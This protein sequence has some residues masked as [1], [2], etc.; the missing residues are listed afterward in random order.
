MISIKQLKYALA[1]QKTLHFKKAAELCNVSP[2]A[3]S[4]A[5]NELEAQLNMKIFERDTKRVLI[6]PSG[7]RILEKATQVLL[8]IED[9]QAL[10]TLY[11][12][13]LTAPMDIGIIPTIAPFLLPQFL[14]L[15]K[16][17]HP[18]M[19]LQVKEERSHVVI[20]Q[21]R[22]GELDAAI[23]ALPYSC[24]GLLTLEFWHEDFYWV[25]HKNNSRADLREISGEDIDEN[26]LLLLQEGH[27]L[28]DH[29]LDACHL[30]QKISARGLSAISLNTLIQMVA[31]GLGTTLVPEM[32]L[33]QLISQN[34]NLVSAHLK[35]PGPHRSIAF[36]TRPNYPRFQ[37]VEALRDIAVDAFK[38][39]HDSVEGSHRG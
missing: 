20:E 6:T 19:N 22:Q 34:P 2:S 11:E 31:G 10:A 4:T 29:I 16:E 30:A 13:P 35:E 3:L 5:L 21:V 1:V 7:R 12:D 24:P 39:I 26:E 18:Q 32:A 17:R 33:P 27:C 15:L 25:A 38:T 9:M 23:I 37:C 14:P 28:K 36:I 8:D